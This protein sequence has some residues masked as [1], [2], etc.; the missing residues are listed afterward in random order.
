MPE[1][2]ATAAA[3]GD[4]WAARQENV[5][6]IKMI[7]HKMRGISIYGGQINFFIHLNI[8]AQ[9]RQKM[10]PQTTAAQI[11]KE[12]NEFLFELGKYCYDL[13][14]LIFAGV[15][16][17]DAF[18]LSNENTLDLITGSIV[19]TGLLIL[20]MIFIKRGTSRFRKI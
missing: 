11:S 19:M 2:V 5:S 16:I 7:R 3:I 17:V 8:I 13:S 18:H 9:N 1:V 12:K 14:K 15:V 10:L 20:G 6:Q 4:K